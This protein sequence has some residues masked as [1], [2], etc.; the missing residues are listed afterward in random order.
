MSKLDLYVYV[1][2]KFQIFFNDRLERNSFS[3]PIWGGGYAERDQHSLFNFYLF[4]HRISTL[5][6]KTSTCR[7][8]AQARNTDS[9]QQ[10]LD[11]RTIA[12]PNG[13]QR[14]TITRLMHSPVFH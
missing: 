12:L 1:Y 10:S 13:P 5:R 14:R 2:G 8:I 3:F 9:D 7:H 4:I 11:F 6:R